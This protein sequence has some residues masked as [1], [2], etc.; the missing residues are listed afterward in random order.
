MLPDRSLSVRVVSVRAPLR[1]CATANIDESTRVKKSRFDL[2][3]GL[4]CSHRHD[5]THEES[6]VVGRMGHRICCRHAL[7]VRS[8][9]FRF[10]KKSLDKV[11]VEIR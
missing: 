8:T 5:L 10:R 7:T 2:H 6:R 1:W 3:T 9:G 11:V 4:V